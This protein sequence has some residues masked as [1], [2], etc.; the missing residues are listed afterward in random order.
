MYAWAIYWL[1]KPAYCGISDADLRLAGEKYLV[2][3]F[4]AE[5]DKAGRVSSHVWV[6][7][8]RPASRQIDGREDRSRMAMMAVVRGPNTPRMERNWDLEGGVLRAEG[9]SQRP[10]MAPTVQLEGMMELPSRGS[11]ARVYFSWHEEEEEEE[12]V[13]TTGRSTGSSSLEAVTMV[14]QE[15]MAW[16]MWA[17]AWTSTLSSGG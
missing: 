5:R 15:V 7:L 14:G 17:S 2:F 12:E 6:R 10:M 3:G 8:S 1:T 9:P 11:K 4:G 16:R 13:W